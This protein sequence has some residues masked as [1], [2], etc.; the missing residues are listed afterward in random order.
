MLHLHRL[1]GEQALALG[2]DIA[3]G[4]VDRGDGLPTDVQPL[5]KPQ[6]EAAAAR[7][8]AAILADATSPLPV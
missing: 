1:E 6:A 8:D 4:D 3:G 2:D 7:I 5:L